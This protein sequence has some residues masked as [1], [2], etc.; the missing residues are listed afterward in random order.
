MSVKS[1]GEYSAND[2]QQIRFSLI[3]LSSQQQ[4]FQDFICQYY[5]MSRSTCDGDGRPNYDELTTRKP[6]S[7]PF[8]AFKT[9]QHYSHH[10]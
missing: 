2:V 4:E 9:C 1:P 8:R 5:N 10:R 3:R 6:I 7:V